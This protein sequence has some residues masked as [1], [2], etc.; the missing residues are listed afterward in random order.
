[1]RATFDGGGGTVEP[2]RKRDMKALKIASLVIAAIVVVAALVLIVGI[3]SGFLT[4]GITER[5]ER[6]TGYRLNVAGS[7]RIGLW[8]S[9]H[10]TM[11]DVTLERLKIGRAF[12]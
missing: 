3:P 12:V 8:P 1:M 6:E 7:A 5:V 9:L 2:I 4:S 10:V 11:R